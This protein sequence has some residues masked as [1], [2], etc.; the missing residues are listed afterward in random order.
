MPLNQV[1]VQIIIQIIA[2]LIAF[3][4]DWLILMA[5]QPFSLA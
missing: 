4:D 5:Y 1:I 3:K 2:T